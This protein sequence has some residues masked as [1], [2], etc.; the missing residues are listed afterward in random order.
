MIARERKF[1]HCCFV[2]FHHFVIIAARQIYPEYIEV[3][4]YTYTNSIVMLSKSLLDT[5]AVIKCRMA[6]KVSVNKSQHEQ[7]ST[8]NGSKVYVCVCMFFYINFLVLRNI[9][10]RTR[11]DERQ[12]ERRIGRG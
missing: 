6:N 8:V 11:G 9:E 2:F 1:C 10:G 7:I 5:P 12:E 4:T 3:C